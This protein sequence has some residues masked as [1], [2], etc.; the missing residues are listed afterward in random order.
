MVQPLHDEGI[1]KISFEALYDT[2]FDRVNRYLRYR[3]ASVWDADDLTASVFTRAL[4]KYHLYRGEAP[5]A[6]WLFRI[7]HNIYVDYI[8]GNSKYIFAD[9]E[10]ATGKAVN[11]QPEEELLR[12]EELEQLRKLLDT[13]AP[14]QRDVV[15]LRYIGDL[16]FGQIAEIIDKTESAVRMIHH[17]ALKVLKKKLREVG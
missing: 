2:Y 8:R 3:V 11:S 13:L 14:E 1:R 4:E 17:R 15:A 12:V 5:V 9:P 7:A 6:V 10:E 16:R